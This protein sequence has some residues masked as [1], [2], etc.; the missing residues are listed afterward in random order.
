MRKALFGGLALAGL[1]GCYGKPLTIEATPLAVQRYYAATFQ[2]QPFD[3]GAVTVLQAD[4]GGLRS[5]TLTPCR[6]NTHI[7]GTRAG[8]L[9]KTEDYSIV[10]DAYPGR[11]FDLSPGGD[12]VVRRHGVDTPIA[13]NE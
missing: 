10:T 1:S 3:E 7:C 2:D 13:W 5:F 8:H 12:G 4:R 6:N 11:V 9:I